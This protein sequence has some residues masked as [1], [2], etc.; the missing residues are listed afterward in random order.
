MS[1]TDTNRG[2]AWALQSDFVTAKGIA[3]GALKQ[4][5]ATDNNFIE[6]TPKTVDNENWS[7]GVN[8]ATDEWIE[9][10]DAKV[11]HTMPGFSQEIG[12]VF[13]LGG[14]YGLSTPSGGTASKKHSFVPNDPNVTRQNKAVT[15][16]EKLAA[17]W[18]VLMPRAVTEG[19]SLKGDALGMLMLDFNLL[20]AGLI[21]PNSGVTW[22]PAATPSVSRIT[23]LHKLFNTQVNLAVTDAGSTTTYGCRYRNFQVDYKLTML[24]DAGFKPGCADFAISGDP[25]SGVILSAHEFDKQMLD[26][27]FTVDMATG[28]PEFIAVQQQKPLTIVLTV[29]GGLIEGAINH[30]LL[31]TIPVGK[32]KASKPT[33]ANGIA[34]FA[35]SGK[36]L[37][38]FAKG[39][40]FSIDLTNDVA[41]Y[42]TA[43]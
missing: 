26:F 5:I 2:Y 21:I 9:A 8:S 32:Y 29:T 11:S 25:T 19:W 37:F 34:S 10:H 7:N 27:S 17:G 16:A 36:G 23:G 20:G 43:F 1:D 42:A 3:A 33:I 24:S 22:Y 35:I 4:I 41:S 14:A 6:Y 40:L 18:N 38:D 12:K 31:L 30:Q 15:Y 28:S 39:K 13:Y